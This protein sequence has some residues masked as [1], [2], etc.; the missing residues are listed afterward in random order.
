MS[1]KPLS[2]LALECEVL[3]GK[4]TLPSVRFLTRF[5]G[6]PK[7]VKAALLSNKLASKPFT[8]Y[9]TVFGQTTNP[10]ITFFDQEKQRL[11]KPGVTNFADN[12][13]PAEQIFF[14]D[15]LRLHYGVIKK[16][17][18]KITQAS[19]ATAENVILTDFWSEELPL[20]VAHA[21]LR[22]SL[23]GKDAISGFLCQEFLGIKDRIRP[24]VKVEGVFLQENVPF[25]FNIQLVGEN[26][27]IHEA[28][29]L[30]LEGVL[31]TRA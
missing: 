8:I 4:Q 12:K 21:A 26:L 2:Q 24:K 18:I 5:N 6:L 31:I 22:L 28:L 17:D 1:I 10:V 20:N 25:E 11:L 14:V 3:A 13:I 19:D 7:E 16:S 29:R 15:N 27:K 23:S 9:D 30:E